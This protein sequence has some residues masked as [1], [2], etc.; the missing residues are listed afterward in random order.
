MKDD[1]G[2]VIHENFDNYL[3]Y[4]LKKRLQHVFVA[5]KHIHQIDTFIRIT[6]CWLYTDNYFIHTFGRKTFYH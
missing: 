1:S 5:K 3:D 4:N 2:F 6:Y